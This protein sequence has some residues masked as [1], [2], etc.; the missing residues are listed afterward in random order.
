VVILC[1]AFAALAIALFGR[2]ANRAASM[3]DEAARAQVVMKRHVHAVRQ[4]IDE[5]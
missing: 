2:Y 4:L 3:P 5:A 1:L